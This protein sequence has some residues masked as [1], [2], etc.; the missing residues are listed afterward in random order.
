MNKEAIPYLTTNNRQSA[1]K[2]KHFT[3]KRN[4]AFLKKI[5][6]FDLYQRNCHR[7]GIDI[8]RKLTIC[9]IALRLT[10][11]LIMG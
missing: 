4:F 3:L 2:F 1:T 8:T 6:N 5:S 11:N 9:W 7:K 10:Y